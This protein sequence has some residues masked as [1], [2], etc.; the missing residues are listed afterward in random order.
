MTPQLLDNCSNNISSSSSSYPAVSSSK[1]KIQ[2]GACTFEFEVM[3]PPG[4][5]LFHVKCAICDSMNEVAVPSNLQTPLNNNLPSRREETI[6]PSNIPVA[7]AVSASGGSLPTT[8]ATSSS[9]YGPSAVP[10]SI[11]LPSQPNF[12]PTVYH[13]FNMTS[14]APIR[15]AL[16]IGINYFNTRAQLRGCIN[17]TKSIQSLLR[18]VYGWRSSSSSTAQTTGPVTEIRVLTDDSHNYATRPVRANIIS[19][20]KW[21]V[22]NVQ[23]GDVLFLSYSGH[24]A[25]KP[26]P[27][28]YEEDGKTMTV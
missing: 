16:I 11:P 25:Q 9:P 26:D 22:A 8:Y 7:T 23:K 28:G 5:R 20:M 17:D 14:R 12:D 3:C 6:Y 2:C 21:L 24:G 10:V 4:Q 27:H 18:D 19:S 1:V 15:R 13:P